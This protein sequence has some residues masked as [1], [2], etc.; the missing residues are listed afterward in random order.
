LEKVPLEEEKIAETVETFYEGERSN[1]LEWNPRT[2][3]RRFLNPINTLG[4]GTLQVETDHGPWRETR[5][6]LFLTRGSKHILF[7]VS[8]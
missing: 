4:K 3:H 2:L 6:T 5:S 7:G 8:D 1:P